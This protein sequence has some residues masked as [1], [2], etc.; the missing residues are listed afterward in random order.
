MRA[1]CRV[2]R[3]G[4][5][6]R[7]LGKRYFSLVAAISDSQSSTEARVCSVISNWTGRPVFFWYDGA[8]FSNSAAGANIV[9]LQSEE[10]TA[11]ELAIDR[12]IEQRE[13]VLEALQLK[14]SSNGPDLFQ[15]EEGPLLTNHASLV[16][17]SLR[18]RGSRHSGFHR[19]SP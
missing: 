8:P 5:A 3:C 4:C 9:D 6:R 2:E 15:F 13:V 14:P 12:Q 7:R 18:V 16:P 17:G 10:I 19:S 11:P 1:Y